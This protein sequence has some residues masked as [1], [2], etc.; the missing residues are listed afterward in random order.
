MIDQVARKSKAQGLPR[1]RL[2]VFS[3]DDQRSI[4]GK[5]CHSRETSCVEGDE[6][7]RGRGVASRETSYV[8][9]DELR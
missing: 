2:P 8:E 4:K 9:G 3:P 6:L 5:K 7:R 1:S